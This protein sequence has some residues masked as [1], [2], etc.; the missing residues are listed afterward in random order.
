MPPCC[1]SSALQALHHDIQHSTSSCSKLYLINA[2]FKPELNYLP[3]PVHPM[4]LSAS[5]AFTWNVRILL[6]YVQIALVINLHIVIVWNEF[7]LING[8]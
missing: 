4:T 6:V 5:A 1:V 8:D 3:L 2:V 7:G